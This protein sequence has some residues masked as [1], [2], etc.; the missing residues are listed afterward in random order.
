VTALAKLRTKPSTAQRHD[1][2]ARREFIAIDAKLESI[3]AGIGVTRAYISQL[4]AGSRCPSLRVAVAIEEHFGIP[5]R[6]WLVA[7]HLSSPSVAAARTIAI[8]G[9]HDGQ[10]G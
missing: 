6:M 1:S 2:A 3:A 4:R 7:T 9:S 10:R 5:C 8:G